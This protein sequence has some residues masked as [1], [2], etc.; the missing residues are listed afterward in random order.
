M[1]LATIVFCCGC[2]AKTA[3]LIE[4][5]LSLAPH[6]LTWV[7]SKLKSLTRSCACLQVC[8]THLASIAYCFGCH[9]K[10]AFLNELP[11]TLAPHALTWVTSKLKSLIGS[12]ACCHAILSAPHFLSWFLNE[13]NVFR[14]VLLWVPVLPFLSYCDDLI[15]HN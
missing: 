4:L 12:R 8:A 13:N 2:H 14:G 11:L 1:H 15:L 6:A 9:A 5:P 10:T 7:I 3:F